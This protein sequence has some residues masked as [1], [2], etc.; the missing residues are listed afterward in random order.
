MA[1]KIMPGKSTPY[2]GQPVPVPF[3][4]FTLNTIIICR[5]EKFSFT[6]S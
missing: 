6:H 2:V 3:K 4:Y 1:F 5:E